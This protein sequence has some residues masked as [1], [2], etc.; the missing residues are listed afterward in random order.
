MLL[1]T[2]ANYRSWSKRQVLT[3]DLDASPMRLPY[4]FLMQFLLTR[5]NWTRKGPHQQ[6]DARFNVNFHTNRACSTYEIMVFACAS[7]LV[8]SRRNRIY[9]LRS[10]HIRRLELRPYDNQKTGQYLV[11]AGCSAGNDTQTIQ[12]QNDEEQKTRLR[13]QCGNRYI[14]SKAPMLLLFPV[15]SENFITNDWDPSIPVWPRSRS[16]NSFHDSER[17]FRNLLSRL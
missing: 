14:W 2:G 16:H 9:Q 6:K 3:K 13:I 15:A 10:H 1:S 11:T 8:W 12:S 7:E 5:R 17:C 4:M